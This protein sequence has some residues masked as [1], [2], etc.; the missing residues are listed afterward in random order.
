MH[1]TEHKRCACQIAPWA[2]KA[3]RRAGERLCEHGD[4]RLLSEAKKARRTALRAADRKAASD[5]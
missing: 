1:A 4:S 2:R 5:A 3:A